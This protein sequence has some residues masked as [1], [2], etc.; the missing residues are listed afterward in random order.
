[1]L[2]VE[3]GLQFLW[4][5]ALDLS[6]LGCIECVPIWGEFRFVGVRLA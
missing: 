3:F 4:P 5:H 6:D 2:L 1:M